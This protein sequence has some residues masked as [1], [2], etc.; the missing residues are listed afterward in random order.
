MIIL[1]ST[2][3][4]AIIVAMFAFVLLAAHYKEYADENHRDLQKLCQKLESNQINVVQNEIKEERIR[5]L[6]RKDGGW[7]YSTMLIGT[8][9]FFLFVFGISFLMVDFVILNFKF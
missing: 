2:F 6:N 4:L 9:S 5:F 3:I 7:Q 1:I 8:F